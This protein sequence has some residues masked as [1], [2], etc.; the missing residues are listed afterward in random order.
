[1]NFTNM[2][3]LVKN[4]RTQ[5][6]D[7]CQT[8]FE[9]SIKVLKHVLKCLIIKFHIIFD[10]M[11]DFIFGLYYDHNIQKVPPIKNDL[12]LTSAS[13]LAE[14]IRTKKISSVEVVT[15]FIN[16]AKEVNGI[17]NAIV[18]DRYSDALEE[19]KEVDK[20]LQTLENID[21]IKDKKPFLGV[22]FTTKE[23]NEAKDMLHTM[24]LTSR[25]T[26][27]SKEDA[28]AI[29]FMKNAGGILIA[30]TNIPE[31]NLWTESRNNVYGQTCNPYNTT[32]NVGGSSGGEGAITAACGT[33][34]SVASDIGGSTRMPAFF[35]GVFGFQSTAGLTP[36]KGIGLRK[37]DYPNSMAGVGPMCKKAEDLVPIL[38]VLVGEKISLLKLDAEVDIKCLNIFYQENS[39]D[40]RASKVN[41]EMRA[42]LLKVVQHFKEI[43][44]SAT[45]IKIP[46]SEYSYRLW[47]FWMTQ[48]NFDF[49]I[50]ITNGKYRASALT[51]ISKFLTGRSDLTL[52]AILKLIDE[53]IFPR[54]DAEWAMNVTTN[55]KQYLM[56][57]LEHNGILIYP[58]SPFQTGYHYTAYL[59][60]F[61]FGYWGLFNVLKFPVCQVPLGVGKNGLPIGVQVV[62]APYNDHLCLAAARE[63]EKV[64]G[65]WVPP[66]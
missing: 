48:E 20:F 46:G 6:G 50:N 28:T 22:P 59:R 25:C 18:E 31:L 44:G 39:G 65:G 45:K 52:A 47:R 8:I 3:T 4:S 51:E 29:S 30:K 34:F 11:I 12:L 49:K 9:M 26:F 19:A 14:R 62:A 37:E 15:A 60:P 58:S 54:E 23:S 40:I 61:N 32:R 55:M 7:K 35:N 10:C 1:M 17:I 66:A 21:S 27:R 42:A 57:K 56:D 13:E 38:K 5:E 24:G 16:R 53:D 2:C 36:L 33:A 63:L 41:S 43:T 64:F